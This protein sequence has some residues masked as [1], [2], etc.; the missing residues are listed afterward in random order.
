MPAAAKRTEVHPHRQPPCPTCS[1]RTARQSQGAISPTSWSTPAKAFKTHLFNTKQTVRTIVTDITLV[2]S[3]PRV[4][5]RRSLLT[6]RGIANLAATTV[7][8]PLLHLNDRRCHVNL[9]R[10][11]VGGVHRKATLTLHPVK[12][13]HLARIHDRKCARQ[14]AFVAMKASVAWVPSI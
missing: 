1:C 4:T 3:P 2:D 6:S 11:S 12:A 5:V 10:V 8:I 14:D 9:G 7:P 13:F